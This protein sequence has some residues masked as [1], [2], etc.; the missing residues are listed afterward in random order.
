MRSVIILAVAAF[1]SPIGAFAYCSEPSA[2]SCAS[3]YGSFDDEW[4]F[5]RCKRDMEDYRSE[6]E[7]FISCNNDEIRKAQQAS[8]EAASEYSEAVDDFNKRAEQ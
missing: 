4:E 6:V 1:F 5:D 7:S 2:P 8:E 3:R